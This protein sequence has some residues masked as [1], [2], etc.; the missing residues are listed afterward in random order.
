MYELDEQD[1]RILNILSDGDTDEDK[2]R[3]T[4]KTIKKYCKYLKDNLDYPC[5]LTGIEDFPWEEK[6]VLGFGSR[7]KY[8]KLKKE[9]PS[10]KDIFA[11]INFDDDVDEIILVKVK[12]QSDNKIFVI[13]LDCL[14][15]TDENSKNY[16]ILDDYSVWY[17]NN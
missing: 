16:Q 17:V 4:T 15:A 10:Y 5:V 13:E 14:K 6:F 2:L 9:N 3:K 7:R 11:L 12:R 1:K 8:E